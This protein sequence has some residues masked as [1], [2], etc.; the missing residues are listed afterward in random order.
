MF[1]HLK[2]KEHISFVYMDMS[3]FYQKAQNHKFQCNWN[4]NSRLQ[5][6]LLTTYLFIYLLTTHLTKWTITISKTHKENKVIQTRCGKKIKGTIMC[7]NSFYWYEEHKG[8]RIERKPCPKSSLLE[9]NTMSLIVFKF[10][11]TYWTYLNKIL[12]TVKTNMV[13]TKKIK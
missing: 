1:S 9:V 8:K 10:T 12:T 11:T 13:W 3:H 6:L 5:Y 7:Q 2:N 4:Q